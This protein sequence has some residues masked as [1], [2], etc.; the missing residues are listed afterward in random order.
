MKLVNEYQKIH[1][2][3]EAIN[4]GMNPDDLERMNARNRESLAKIA[5]WYEPMS[6]TM[7]EHR[8][9]IRKI[10]RNKQRRAKNR[11]LRDLCGTSARAARLDMGL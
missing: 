6:I 11:I 7:S 9:K 5:E 4:G 8:E 10:R 2:M 3:V 1:A